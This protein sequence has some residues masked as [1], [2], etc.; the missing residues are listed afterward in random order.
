MTTLVIC[1]SFRFSLRYLKY[2]VAKRERRASYEIR[3]RRLLSVSK[4]WHGSDAQFFTGNIATMVRNLLYRLS[5]QSGVARVRGC[6]VLPLLV[7]CPLE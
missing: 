7:H 1:D 4:S 2:H 6:R 5:L 3:V